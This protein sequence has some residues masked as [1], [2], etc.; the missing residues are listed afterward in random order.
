MVGR[1]DPGK[2]LEIGYGIGRNKQN[3]IWNVF[4]DAIA[5]KTPISFF[6]EIEN[7]LS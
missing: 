4:T 6:I 3:K 2:C 1:V 7:K 5:M